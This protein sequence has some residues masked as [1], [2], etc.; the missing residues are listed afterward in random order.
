MFLIVSFATKF[1]KSNF[2]SFFGRLPCL[3]RSDDNHAK[4]SG[5]YHM[6][7]IWLSYDEKINIFETSHL[8]VYV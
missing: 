6:I 4:L 3:K 1:V 7:I 8:G 5:D 2:F